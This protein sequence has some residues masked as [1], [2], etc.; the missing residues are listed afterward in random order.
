VTWNV[1]LNTVG[2]PLHREDGGSM[3]LQTTDILPHSYI[4]S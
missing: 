1:S 2:V 4:V 3:A